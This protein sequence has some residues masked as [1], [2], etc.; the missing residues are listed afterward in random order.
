MFESRKDV[1]TKQCCDYIVKAQM[2]MEMAVNNLR[3]AKI[4]CHNESL[5]CNETAINALS[6]LTER[7]IYDVQNLV[8]YIHF[9]GEIGQYYNSCER[10]EESEYNRNSKDKKH[11]ESIIKKARKRLK[12]YNI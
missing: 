9:I 11:W 5:F 6:A 4:I 7:S 2:L 1:A 12:K 3:M 8:F 10:Y